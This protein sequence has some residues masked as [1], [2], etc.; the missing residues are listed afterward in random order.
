MNIVDLDHS[1][2]SFCKM[3]KEQY[4]KLMIM[5]GNMETHYQN[6]LQYFAI[7]PKKTSVE[8]LFADL[9]NF[10]CMFTVSA[11][12]SVFCL[13]FLSMLPVQLIIK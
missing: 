8:E 10:R 2:Y 5:H 3:A 7:D 11:H 1:H 9:S 13:F 12:F 4:G 6:L